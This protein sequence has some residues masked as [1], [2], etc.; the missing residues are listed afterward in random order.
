MFGF[1]I[2]YSMSVNNSLESAIQVSIYDHILV[3]TAWN[4]FCNEEWDQVGTVYVDPEVKN[5][6]DVQLNKITE[7]WN[8]TPTDANGF[9]IPTRTEVADRINDGIR[10]AVKEL[11]EAIDNMLHGADETMTIFNERIKDKV[12]DI[13]GEKL[14]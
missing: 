6:P 5:L 10:E 14:I 13:F 9:I 1:V 4:H 8:T 12:D 3:Q 2:I 7:I 11:K